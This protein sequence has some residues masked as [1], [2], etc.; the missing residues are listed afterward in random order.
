[1]SGPNTD[2]RTLLTLQA[3]Q[4]NPKLSLRRAA[5]IYKIDE[6]RLRRRR[7]G[8]Q[9]RRD[10]IPKSRRLSD[11][12]EQIIVQFIL[13]LYSRGFPPRLRSVQEMA[14]RLLTDRGISPIGINWASNFMKRQP[15]LKTHFQRSYGYQRARCDDPTIIRSKHDEQD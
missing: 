14:N 2:A 4:N 10:W 7:Q 9:S 12:E 5:G 13:D 1:M 3:L 11:L 8:I 6:R 15:E